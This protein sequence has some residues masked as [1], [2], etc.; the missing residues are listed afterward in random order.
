MKVLR[1]AILPALAAALFGSG[2]LLGHRLFSA[3]G[4][5]VQVT[6]QLILTALRD[7]G[8]LVSK[9]YVLDESVTIRKTSGS[10]FGDFFVGQTITAR[11]A[12][13]V[14]VGL[15]LTRISEKDVSV[16]DGEVAVTIPAASLFNVRLAGPVDVKNEQGI[17][18]RLFQNEDGYNESLA[19]LSDRAAAAARNPELL[20][21][22]GESGREELSRL[23]RFVAPGRRITVRCADGPRR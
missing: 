23:L 9:T 8:F 20:K 21:G 17:V 7:Q 1:L 14:N 6:A 13:E 5:Q 15:D 12:M 18:K 3:P 16:A 10:A 19:Q 4:G 2:L 11:G 22:A